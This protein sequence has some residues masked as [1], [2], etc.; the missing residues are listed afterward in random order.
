M[1]IATYETN[2]N[3]HIDYNDSLWNAYYGA[4]T[5][6]TV[7]KKKIF[8][9]DILTRQWIEDKVFELNID[10]QI[11]DLVHEEEQ[12]LF[13]PRQWTVEFRTNGIVNVSLQ[14]NMI[15]IVNGTVVTV[16]E[17][18]WLT[19]CDFLHSKVQAWP[20][21]MLKNKSDRGWIGAY[22]C[23][24]S[25]VFPDMLGAAYVEIPTAVTE[26][27]ISY[28]QEMAKEEFGF[29]PTYM[30][31]I[32]GMRHMIDFCMRPLDINICQ[33]RHLVGKDYEKL[34][35]REQSDNYR[36]LCR[37][38]RI[39]NPPKS[40]RKLYGES[41]ESIVAYLL[42]RQ[43]GFCD[44][45]VI[46]RFFYRNKLFSWSLMS[47]DYQKE[48]SRLANSIHDRDA[49]L[50]W[51]ERFCHWY[52][53]YRPETALA[54][55]LHPLAVSD[56]WDQDAIDI[57]RMFIEANINEDD[58]ILHRDTKRRLLRDG[59]T[60]EVHDFLMEELPGILPQR[61]EWNFNNLPTKP[62]QNIVIDYTKYELNYEDVIDDYHIVLPKDTN[63]IRNYG[64]RFHN[65]VSS[66][67][68]SVVGK[69]TL[70]LAMIKDEKYIACLEVQQNRLVQ[71]LGPCN[72]HLSTAIGE[73]I[74][75][76]ADDKKIA[77]KVKR[78]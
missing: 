73:I 10:E 18:E 40:L 30:G 53:Q 25:T 72:Q 44:I 75:R 74:C 41:P 26:T 3:I 17:K 60:H 69:R 66:Y 29:N 68:S 43:L 2:E 57:L 36:V 32:H 12:R 55:C 7:H 70:I 22:V 65:C 33:F 78:K 11:K 47:M 35:P 16:Q 27:A 77:Y 38:F 28:M 5:N 52:L 61:R 39:D 23:E 34:F 13:I 71:A 51:L 24:E 76:W 45:N 50:Y 48:H 56:E 54:N 8:G 20:M 19:E 67:C 62:L 46:R 31:N 4:G 63:E 59:F 9:Y 37:F 49:Y 58:S 14:L 64:K 42:L 6:V 15:N 21:T 1:K